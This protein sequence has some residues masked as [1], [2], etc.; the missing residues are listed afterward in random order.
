MLSELLDEGL[1]QLG[2]EASD[3]E[4]A[5][6]KSTAPLVELGMAT[7]GYVDDIVRGVRELGP[8]VVIAPHVALPHARPESG[9]LR[10]AIG[11]VTL[12]RPVP[13]GSPE[14]DPVGY[15]FPLS[16]TDSDGHLGALQALVV[17]LRAPAFLERLARARSAAEVLEIVREMEGSSV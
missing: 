8:Y 5:V 3:W 11:V 17:L 15:H 2:V 9:A 13:F 12:A 1:V 10:A 6:R 16:A 7:Q 4:D 14:L